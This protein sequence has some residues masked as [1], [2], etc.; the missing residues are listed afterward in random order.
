MRQV[1]RGCSASLS[2]CRPLFCF[3][4]TIVF[5]VSDSANSA[6]TRFGASGSPA[7]T[8]TRSCA[9][10]YIRPS[11]KD[12]GIIALRKRRDVPCHDLPT[13]RS[14]SLFRQCLVEMGR[15]DALAHAADDY[16]RADN[17]EQVPVISRRERKLFWMLMRYQHRLDDIR[18]RRQQPLFTNSS[19]TAVACQPRVTKITVKFSSL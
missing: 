1:E 10:E 14:I 16:I 12:I 17:P 19:W 13:D 6:S 15:D 5:S 9:S 2:F 4:Q 18:R 7:S 3:R 11:C 8:G